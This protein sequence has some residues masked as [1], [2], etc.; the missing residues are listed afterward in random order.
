MLGLGRCGCLA[1]YLP[2]DSTGGIYDLERNS[3]PRWR[4][5]VNRYVAGGWIGIGF[6]GNWF[7]RRL[8]S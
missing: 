2:D 1:R 7:Y 5:P 3:L 8:R 6:N 4:T